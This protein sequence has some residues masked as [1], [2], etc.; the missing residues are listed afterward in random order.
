V[1]VPNFDELVGADEPAEERERLRRAHE[2]LLAAGPP[3]ELPPSLAKPPGAQPPP[4]ARRQPRAFPRRRLAASLVL[5][6]ALALAAFG[7][8][9]LAGNQGGDEEAF[10]T[11]FVQRMEG[12]AAAPNALASIVVGKKDDD[13]N[14]PMVMTVLRLE[15]LPRGKRYELVLTKAGKPAVSCGTFTIDDEQTVVYLNAPY[16]L[17][18][19]DGWAITREDSDEILVRSERV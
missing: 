2:A 12:T 10:E 18:A 9:Y 11:D 6:A 14:W 1:K 19:Y 3:P 8:G 17:N 15:P 7:A 5:A 4:R 13:G 16:R